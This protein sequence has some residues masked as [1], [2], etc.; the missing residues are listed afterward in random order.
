MPGSALGKG[1]EQLGGA[2][3]DYAHVQDAI[4]A[5]NDETQAMK[6]AAD[7]RT[8]MAAVAQQFRGQLGGNARAGQQAAMD[9]ITKA[10]SDLI[11]QATNP[12]MAR[13]LEQHIDRFYGDA[14]EQVTT[15]AFQQAQVE[16]STAL[17]ANVDALSDSAIAADDPAKRLGYVQQAVQAKNA[18]LDFLGVTD[19]TTRAMEQRDTT[20]GIH[21]GVLDNMLADPNRD[22]NLV[23]A[24]FAAHRDEMTPKDSLAVERDLQAPLHAQSLEA[25]FVRA[26][27]AGAKEQGAPADG[28]A[29]GVTPDRMTAITAQSES[30]NRDLNADGSLVTSPKGAMGRMQVMPAT[31][32]DPG[33]GI[34]PWDGKNTDDLARV[35]V[36]LQNA[37]LK[38]YGDPAKAW[39][40]YNWGEGHVDDAVSKYGAAWLR[41]APAETRDYVAKNMAALGDGS[42][43]GTAPVQWDKTAVYAKIDAQAKAEG[44]TWEFTQDMKQLADRKI[45]QDEGLVRHQRDMADEAAVRAVTQ[46]GD[47]FTS[48]NQLPQTVRDQL[49]PEAY[50]RYVKQA[51]TNATPDAPKAN[52]QTAMSLDIM[53][54]EEP[55]K[56]A[57]MNL[58]ELVG[59]ITPGEMSGYL[60]KQAEMRVNAQKPQQPWSPASGISEAVGYG[61]RIGNLKLKDDEK[62]AVMQTMEAEATQLHAAGKPIDFHSLFQHATRNVKVSGLFGSSDTPLYRLSLSNMRDDQRAELVGKFRRE[63]GRPPNDDELLRLYRVMKR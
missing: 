31:A 45:A 24:Y 1:L 21:R 23:Q 39:A 27:T 17:K 42:H 60:T 46:M 49:S 33:H 30:G 26:M 40:A 47:K 6:M 48:I 15:H 34:A 57:A 19:P 44:W 28:S 52:S 55:A 43:I 62:S 41:S 51:E 13:M 37:L 14:T 38:K 50:A 10:K 35:G 8:Q 12:R 54:I 63:M 7:G 36:Q 2:V 18:H 58:G 56:F 25:G 59:K 32:R 4:N 3:Q 20:S 5:Q 16:H 29:P 53:R 61:E 9:Q 22:V 11:A